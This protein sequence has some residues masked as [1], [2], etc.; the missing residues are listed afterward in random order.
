MNVLTAVQEVKS[1]FYANTELNIC[2][3]LF[4][5]CSNNQ[6][7][8]EATFILYH[9]HLLLPSVSSQ[10]RE[11][12]QGDKAVGGLLLQRESQATEEVCVSALRP[13]HG[14]SRRGVCPDQTR[15]PARRGGVSHHEEISQHPNYHAV[16]V[17]VV[18][19]SQRWFHFLELSV[20]TLVAEL[21]SVS[22]TSSK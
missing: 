12:W 5:S 17:S 19:H 2:I 7:P 18:G 10:D 16:N 11:D 22:L 13:A 9:H 20:I 1:M 15:Q 6:T 14:R 8:H 4:W 21:A 3:A